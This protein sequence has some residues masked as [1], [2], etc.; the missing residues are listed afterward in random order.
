M[1]AL[2]TIDNQIDL[3]ILMLTAPVGSKEFDY[4]LRQ[5]RPIVSRSTNTQKVI[6][7]SIKDFQMIFNEEGV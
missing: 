1:L 3:N 5:Y 7:D 2:E 6:K 4:Q